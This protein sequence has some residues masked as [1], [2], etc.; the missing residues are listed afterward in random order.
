MN[1]VLDKIPQSMRAVP[2]WVCWR[3]NDQGGV[4]K[5][6]RQIDGTPAASNRPDRKSVV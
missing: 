5:C 6:P 3:Y 2:N 1:M 4:D